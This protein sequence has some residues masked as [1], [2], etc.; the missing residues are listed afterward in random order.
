MDPY[1]EQ[2]D[3]NPPLRAHRSCLWGCLGTVI[4]AVVVIAAVYSYGAW[5]FYRGFSD[6]PRIQM[7]MDVVR[8]NDEAA[9]VLGKNI[10]PQGRERYTYDYATGR[11]GTATY[12]LKVVGSNGE[13]RLK[14][15]LD[16]SGASTKIKSLVL[17]DSDGHP[18]YL[19][20][21]A[22]PNPLMQN[23]I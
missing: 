19:V 21:A 22:P 13:G 15:E 12:I 17:I 3:Q 2:E 18:H 16:I 6:D 9:S 1:A 8:K 14:A 5:Y 7:V 11:G 4:A 20:G 23:S 10:S